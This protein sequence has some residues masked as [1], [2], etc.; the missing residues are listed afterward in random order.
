[1]T[2]ISAESAHVPGN[3]RLLRLVIAIGRQLAALVLTLLA[4]SMVCFFAVNT[5]SPH[6]IA[7]H[8]LGR[9][10]APAD[11]QAFIEIHKLDS[12]AVTRYARWL[13]AFAQGD[14][15]TSA[16][17]NRPVSGD[18][19]PRLWRSLI[20]AGIALISSLVIALG[21]AAYLARRAGGIADSLM[22]ILTV[23]LGFPEFVLGIVL[24][25]IFGVWLHMLPIDSTAITYGTSSQ[26]IRAY[27]LPIMT[28]TVGLIPYFVRVGRASIRDELNE[29]YL[30]AALLRGL[31]PRTVMWR[32]AVPNAASP[33]INGVALNIASIV[34]GL[35]VLENL[36]AFPGIG[37]LLVQAIGAGDAFTV[38]A[39]A[40]VLGAIIV[41]TSLAADLLIV[42]F[43]PRLRPSR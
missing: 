40:M 5:R 26:H 37:Q 7:T 8:V 16:V 4:I 24:I 30:R 2:A 23:V 14:M 11:I 32:H 22:L 43:N 19:L 10:V 31:K 29:P 38:E 21:F 25:L 39:V 28:L 15:G 35:I 36:F 13:A 12:P 17:T 27:V 9:E 1:M 33:I 18:L 3:R 34:G 6:A 42:Y 20:L 41:C